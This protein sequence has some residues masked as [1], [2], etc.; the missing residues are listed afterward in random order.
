MNEIID[1]QA[2]RLALRVRDYLDAGAVS[3]RFAVGYLFL[4]GLIPL[5]TQIERLANVEILIG[6]VVNRLTREQM[7]EEAASRQ[8]G[9]EAWVLDREDVAA[10]LRDTHDRAAV[11]TALNLRETLAAL[12]KSD[13][14][15]A[16][17]LTLAECV[18]R[19]SLK[20]RLYTQG[21]IHAKVALIGYPEG[22]P[23]APGLAVVGSSNLTL[24]GEA[25][26][27]ELNVALRDADSFQ[28]LEHWYSRLWD[29]SQDFHREL[30][31]ELGQ[32]WALCSSDSGATLSEAVG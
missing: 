3:A 29:V 5:Q 18:A 24:G 6:N 25:H 10:T 16:L 23:D 13:E 4:D 1:N 12:D 26:P 30:F 2:Q 14:M 32:S 19:R 22:H 7:R 27:T 8:R 20:V 9:G 11:E 15:R 17:L 21:R 28:E 31:I